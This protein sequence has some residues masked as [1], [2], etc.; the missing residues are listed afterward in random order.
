MS[1][2]IGH[3]IRNNFIENSIHSVWIRSQEIA[4]TTLCVRLAA[5]PFKKCLF[6]EEYDDRKVGLLSIKQTDKKA[7][8]PNLVFVIIFANC[9]GQIPLIKSPVTLLAGKLGKP[10]W[11]R[12]YGE[13]VMRKGK[14][15]ALHSCLRFWR[16]NGFGC[17]TRFKTD[18]ALDLPIIKKR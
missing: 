8:L 3:A 16:V 13:K 5:E 17:P 15:C 7:E 18:N 14:N 11:L 1:K 6:S 9:Y 10:M 4:E 12:R 2:S